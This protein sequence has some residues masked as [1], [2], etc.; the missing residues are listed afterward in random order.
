MPLVPAEARPGGGRSELSWPPGKSAASFA[1][2]D[3]ARQ[4]PLPAPIELGFVNNMPDAAL[5]ATERQFLS[6]IE[7][8]AGP[9]DVR[10]HF[11]A[12]AD[13]P[14]NGRAERHLALCYDDLEA[15]VQSPLDAV[16]ITG[17]EPKAA[18]LYDEPYWGSLARLFDWAESHTLSAL[19]SCLSAHAAVLHFDGIER[20]HLKQKCSGIFDHAS[21]RYH[22]LTAGLADPWPVAHSR[23][24]GL[25]E[26][27]LRAAGYAVLS[28]SEQAGVNLFVRQRGSLL[29]LLQ[30]H[31]E[32]DA[33]SLFREYRRDVRRYLA[34]EQS[35][36][37]AIPGGCFDAGTTAALEAFRAAARERRDP[38]LMAGF[39]ERAGIDR[40][41]LTRARQGATRLFGNWLREIAETKARTHHVAALPGAAADR[42]KRN[43]LG[44]LRLL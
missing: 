16:I 6:L 25:P 17:N 29:V 33:D 35:C 7:A 27:A 4:A 11:F 26:P 42:T 41:R 18:R 3:E 2:N 44:S 19:F 8:G 39:P 24:N 20:M 9:I 15:L 13:V 43:D 36:W 31:P 28:L 21:P 23:W 40:T 12:L 38:D 32:Y 30:G 1:V 5:E 14:H 10:V 37:P 34:G 22:P